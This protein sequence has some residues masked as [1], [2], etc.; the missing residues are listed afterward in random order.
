[1]KILKRYLLIPM[2]NE[3]INSMPNV[4][5]ETTSNGGKITPPRSALFHPTSFVPIRTSD[6]VALSLRYPAG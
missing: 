2:K 3:K 6:H 5:T 4:Q 1:M